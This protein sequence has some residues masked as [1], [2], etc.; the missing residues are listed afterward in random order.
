M[1]PKTSHRFVVC[2]KNNNF[3]ASLEPRKIYQVLPDK[4]AESHNMIRVVD[5]SGEDY[6][7]PASLFSPISLPQTLVEEL[8]LSL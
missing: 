5:E 2:L 8:A 7:F 3:E 4:E 6:L 1:T